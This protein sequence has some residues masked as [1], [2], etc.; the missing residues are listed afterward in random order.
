MTRIST[1]W[2]FWPAGRLAEANPGT[3]AVLVYELDAGALQRRSY[4][5]SGPGPA[6]KRAVLSL[7]SLDGWNRNG[8][9]NSQLILGPS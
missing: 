1:L 9:S 2:L 7:Q 5:G 4:L 6:P 8:S 3:A